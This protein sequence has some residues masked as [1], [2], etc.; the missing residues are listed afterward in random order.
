MGIWDQFVEF[1][2]DPATW[3]GTGS[4]WVRLFDHLWVSVAA[5]VIAFVLVFPLALYLGH[6]RKGSQAATAVVNIGRAL[7]SFGILAIAFLVLIE[8]GVAGVRSPWPILLALIALAAPPVF[9]NTIAG[10]QAVQPSTVEA[11]R[12]MGL[13]ERQILTGIELPLA[14][15]LVMEGLRIAFVQVIATATLGAI[16]AWGGLGRYIIDGF[17]IRDNGE[18]LFGALAV[19][20]LAIAAEFA[21]SRIHRAVVPKGLEVSG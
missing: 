3:S 10:I 13:T 19:G 20:L 5:T 9:T 21:F 15:P 14:M 2:T 11:A 1:V 18:I 7:P 16:V 6:I 12:G 17:A 8:M 4:F